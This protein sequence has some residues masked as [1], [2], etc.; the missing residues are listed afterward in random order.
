MNKLVKEHAAERAA[1]KREQEKLKEQVA[2]LVPEV[3]SGML[4][5]VNKDVAQAFLQEKQL[6][7]EIQ[8]LQRETNTFVKRS[9]EWLTLVGE[10]NSSLKQLGEMESW[11]RALEGDMA[12]ILERLEYLR[13]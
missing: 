1:A 6:E 8:A 4:D 11:S 12:D 13:Q 7:S 3:T 10:L 2:A 5:S 9:N